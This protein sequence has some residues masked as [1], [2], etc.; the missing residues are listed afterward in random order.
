MTP[1]V[2]NHFP[3]AIQEVPAVPS[4]TLV[5]RPCKVRRGVEKP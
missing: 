3:G 1:V 4:S 2:E 5:L